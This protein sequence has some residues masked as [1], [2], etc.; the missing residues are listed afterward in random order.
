MDRRDEDFSDDKDFSVRDAT[1]Y[2]PVIRR[3][4]SLQKMRHRPFVKEVTKADGD[5]VLGGTQN[6]L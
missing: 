3:G 6:S 4:P 2:M 1:M 5:L